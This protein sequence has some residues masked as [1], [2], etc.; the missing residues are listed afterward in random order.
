MYYGYTENLEKQCKL[1]CD[2][3]GYGSNGTAHLLIHETACTE[4]GAGYIK[5]GTVFAG[6]GLTQF[7]KKPF[8]DIK[9]RGMKYRNKIK[10]DLNIDIYFIQW[11]HLRYNAF[12]G[13]L[14]CRLFYLL[15]RPSIPASLEGRAKYWK[16]YYN[17][18]LGKGTKEHYIKMVATYYKADK[19]A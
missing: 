4:T 1:I 16:K 9:K 17:T 15:K 8:Y 3:L 13:L 5:D 6:M 18:F 14:F 2:C 12:L 11:E 7:D 19:V 10:K